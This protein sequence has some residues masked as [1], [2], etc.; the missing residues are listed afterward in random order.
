VAD[1]AAM[2]D[3][4]KS[5]RSVPLGKN[6]VLPVALAAALPIIAVLALQLPIR[7]LVLT[8]LKAIL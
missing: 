8:L 1:T 4:V 5:M 3:A 6:S 7:Q 2:Y